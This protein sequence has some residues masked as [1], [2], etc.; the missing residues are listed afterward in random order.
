[1]VVVRW[2]RLRCVYYVHGRMLRAILL[3]FLL[4]GAT[5]QYVARLEFFPL[6]FY[7]GTS[8]LLRYQQLLR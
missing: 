3:A 6:Y 2:Q 8:N 1:M 4:A 5:K 7:L